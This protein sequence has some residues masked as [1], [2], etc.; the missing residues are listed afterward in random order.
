MDQGTA[1]TEERQRI[2][3]LPA[4]TLALIALLVAIH[5]I[6]V[7]ILTPEQSDWIIVHF[8]FF[9]SAFTAAGSPL[10]PADAGGPWTFV[11]YAFLHGNYMHLILNCIWLAAFGSPL[12]WRFGTLRFLLFSAVT[13]AAGA[14]AYL[15]VHGGEDAVLVGASG[16]LSGYMEAASRFLF[17]GGGPFMRNWAAPAAPLSVVFTDRRTLSFV[18]IWFAVNIISGLTGGLG[19]DV[20]IAWEAH[21][22]GFVAGLL[23]FPVFDPPRWPS[24]AG[25][26][27]AA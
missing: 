27:R 12:A 24:E 1:E 25:E 21:V 5:V 22:G 6:R 13:A 16:A 20:A 2:F 26:R 7:A 8:G 15:L 19:A 9:P 10:L 11:T 4:V 17:L 18:G 23:L 14:G 3:N